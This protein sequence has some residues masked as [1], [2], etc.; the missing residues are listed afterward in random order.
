MDQF[1]LLRRSKAISCEAT[2]LKGPPTTPIICRKVEEH[3]RAR[4][5]SGLIVLDAEKSDSTDCLWSFTADCLL[6]DEVI[7]ALTDK[8]CTGFSTFAVEAV[9]GFS[10]K[11]YSQFRA[12]GWGGFASASSGIRETERCDCC[13]FLNYSGAVQPSQIFD[14]SQWDGSDVFFVWP[15]P[16]IICLSSKAAGVFFNLAVTGVEVEPIVNFPPAVTGGY[17]PGRLSNW[18]G[19]ERGI[20]IGQPFGI[21]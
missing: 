16:R 18:I 8:G 9:G 20:K 10:G 19:D 4:R 14:R 12:T 3:R 21:D 15:L 17:S 5:R 1:F 7:G 6:N 2:L 13:G 11:T